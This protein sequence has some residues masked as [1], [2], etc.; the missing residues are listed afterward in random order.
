MLCRLHFKYLSME[1]IKSS[2]IQKVYIVDDHPL[3]CTVLAEILQEAGE[4]DVVGLARDG[5]SAI[6]FLR[7]NK[8]DILLLDIV[9][10]GLSG[11]EI[12]AAIQ[13]L[14]I[15]TKT[16][17]ISGLK[18]DDAIALAFSFGAAAYIDKTTDAPDV[19]AN[20]RAVVRG[21]FP[22]NAQANKVLRD[23]IIRRA[24]FKALSSAD[25]LILKGLAMNLSIKEIAQEAGVSISAVYKARARIAGRTGATNPLGFAKA[26]A[27]YGLIS[28]HEIHSRNPAK[29]PVGQP[30]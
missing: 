8:V 7:E 3:Y 11:M 29:A 13:E 5:E 25:L 12:L 17:A 21:E 28:S 10:P 1:I 19:I 23:M 18:S 2:S 15:A 4:F 20:L 24:R 16:V 22:C 9:L 30:L 27:D 14:K 26:A 6:A